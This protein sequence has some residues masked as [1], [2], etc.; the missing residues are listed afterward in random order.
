MR[1]GTSLRWLTSIAGFHPLKEEKWSVFMW[2]TRGSPRGAL[3]SALVRHTR[4]DT[5]LMW[6][7]HVELVRIGAWLTSWQLPQLPVILPLT[8]SRVTDVSAAREPAHVAHVGSSVAM[9]TT[10]IGTPARVW[11]ARP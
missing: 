10:A 1:L 5:S 3:G 9:I 4:I 11:Q 6:F 7:S 8:T 2:A